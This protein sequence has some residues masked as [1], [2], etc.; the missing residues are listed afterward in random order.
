MINN[1]SPADSDIAFIFLCRII[2]RVADKQIVI[3]PS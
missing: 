2:V 3:V 1:Y